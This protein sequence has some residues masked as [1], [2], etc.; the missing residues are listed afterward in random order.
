M[1]FVVQGLHDELA[2]N[3]GTAVFA[4]FVSVDRELHN[5]CGTWSDALRRP[6]KMLAVLRARVRMD[7]GLLSDWFNVCQGLRQGCNLPHP[8]LLLNLFFAARCLL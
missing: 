2:K 3:K 8:P 7:S 5:C 1:L 6:P 4:F